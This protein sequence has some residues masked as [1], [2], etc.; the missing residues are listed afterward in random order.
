MRVLTMTKYF[1]GNAGKILPLSLTVALSVA[2]AY[3]L[4]LLSGSVI[5]TN[6]DLDLKPYEQMSILSGT[7]EALTE[8][9]K[10]KDYERLMNEELIDRRL[11]AEIRQVNY[12]TLTA[13][14]G[15]NVLL[16]TPEDISL[17]LERQKGTLTEGVMPENRTEILLPSELA[18][19]YD[20]SIGDTV[21]KDRIG[22]SIHEDVKIV[23]IYKGESIVAYCAEEK[24]NLALGSAAMIC[25]PQEGNLEEM[26]AFLEKS[27]GNRY[28]LATFERV[29]NTI[30]ES[31]NAI[32]GV[33]VV[34]GMIIC[35]TLS[36]L[37]SNICMTQYAQRAKEFQLLFALG[38]TKKR[39]SFQVLREIGSSNLLGCIAGV[40]LGIMIGWIVNVSL[41]VDQALF[42][43]LLDSRALAAVIPIPLAVTL[44]CMIP[45]LR[46]IRE[47][48][49]L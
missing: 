10:N 1:R 14:H 29:E 19:M 48:T 24:E 18:D 37:L 6:E 21:V 22:W 41:M 30:E 39:I 27:F 4:I 3:F 44:F 34:V 9:V 26:N 31:K 38:Y 46:L 33:T 11:Y 20:L 45:P 47:D 8:E 25:L 42:M 5:S 32:L 13:D 40:S 2:F 43:N 28:N 49:Q 16:M 23:G 7:S 15:M 12:A 36:I 35:I 17:L